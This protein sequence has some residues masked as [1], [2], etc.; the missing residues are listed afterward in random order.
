MET[1]KMV[2]EVRSPNNTTGSEPMRG[3]SPGAYSSPSNS[4]TRNDG[5]H[6]AGH[7]GKAAS[8]PVSLAHDLQRTAAGTGNT[9]IPPTK[10]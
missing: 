8:S 4:R 2:R 6:I 9:V 1:S 5:G 7:V 10:P 3:W